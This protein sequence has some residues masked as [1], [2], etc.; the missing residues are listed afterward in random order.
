MRATKQ[1]ADRS[2]LDSRVKRTEL[3][4]AQDY[5]LQ[6]VDTFPAVYGSVSHVDPYVDYVVVEMVVPNCP[7]PVIW[8]GTLSAC[9]DKWVPIV[10]RGA[11]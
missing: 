2:V 6:M 3:K 10:P 9:R 4:G 5:L 1:L 8:A 7:Q 11:V